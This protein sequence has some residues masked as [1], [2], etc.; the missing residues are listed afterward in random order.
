MLLTER[1]RVLSRDGAAARPTGPQGR[2]QYG[3]DKRTKQDTRP[4]VLS[5][6][7]KHDMRMNGPTV[8]QPVQNIGDE[9]SSQPADVSAVMLCQ[10]SRE[11]VSVGDYLQVLELA[12]GALQGSLSA[13]T[14]SGVDVD[15]LPILA[16]NG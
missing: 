11:M 13:P 12:V 9:V 3:E 4:N 14:R 8:Q 7:A 1:F 15:A 16:L 2:P 5:H 6:L 10:D